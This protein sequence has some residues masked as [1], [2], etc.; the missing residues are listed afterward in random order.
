MTIQCVKAG[1]LVEV[2]RKGRRF[3][4]EVEERAGRELFIRP[5]DRRITYRTC[6][7]REVVGHWHKS[8]RAVGA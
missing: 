2:D 6:T 7:S 5:L 8:K 3:H 1:D 4:A